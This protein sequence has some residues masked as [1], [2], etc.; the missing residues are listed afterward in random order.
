MENDPRRRGALGRRAVLAAALAASIGGCADASP[1]G[2]EGEEGDRPEPDDRGDADDGSSDDGPGEPTDEPDG[3]GDAKAESTVVE[4]VLLFDFEDLEEWELPASDATL[5]GE[6]S[7][8]GG[9]SVRFEVGREENWARLERTGLDLD[10][11]EHRL[12]LVTRVHAPDVPGQSVDVVLTDREGTELRLRGRI[13]KTGTDTT[14]MPLDLGIRE[15][16]PDAPIDLASVERLRVQSRF[17]DETGGELWV[18]ALYAT[19][20]P[21]TPVLTIHWDDGYLSQYTEGFPI[22]RE[23][24]IPAT[25]FVVPTYIGRDDERLTLDQL[26]ELQDEGWDVS[27]H[28][29]HHDNLTE[30]PP[31]EQETQIRDAKE[32]LVDNGFEEGAEYFAYP[33][34]EHDQSSYDLVEEY[35]TFG[36][37]GSEPGYGRPRNLPALGRTSERTIEDASAYVDTLVEWGGYGGLFWHRIP[38]ETPIAEFDEIMATIAERRDDGDIAVV[39]LSELDDRLRASW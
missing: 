25:T 16:D 20:L 31:E 36:L 24:G 39:T 29:Y 2:N 18:D 21:E 4:D 15:W 1:S 32:W 17:D 23:Y 30:L 35:H 9:S 10:L 3:D 34:G 6:T 14:L 5:D 12:S 28:L 33:Y 38:D 22:Q 7:L 19:P 8:T 26:H 27:S 13:R 11:S 37:I